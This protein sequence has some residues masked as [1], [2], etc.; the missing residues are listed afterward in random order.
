VEDLER[1][2]EKTKI[3]IIFIEHDMG[4]ISNIADRV[5]VLNAGRI[6]AEGSFEEVSKSEEVRT[7]YLGS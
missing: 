4:V 7:A 1:I 2:R 6:I 5:I 3:S